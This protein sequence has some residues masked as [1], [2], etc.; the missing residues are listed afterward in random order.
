MRVRIQS[1]PP[2]HTFKAWLSIENLITIKD[3][4]KH[5]LDLLDVDERLVLELDGFELL[6]ESICTQVLRE[7]DLIVCVS[8]YLYIFKTYRIKHQTGNSETFS[9][10]QFTSKTDEETENSPSELIFERR[11]FEFGIK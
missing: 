4:K 7:N 3:L 10:C 8:Q 9:V 6:H 11:V 5:C 2:L 1:I